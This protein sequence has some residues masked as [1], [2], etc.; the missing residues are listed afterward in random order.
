MNWRD[1]TGILGK[2]KTTQLIEMEMRQQHVPR[3]IGDNKVR[4]LELPR[5]NL[6]NTYMINRPYDGPEQED[7]FH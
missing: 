4:L 3:C 6:H 5:Y 2:N 1:C 7:E